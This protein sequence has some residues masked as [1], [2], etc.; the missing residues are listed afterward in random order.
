VPVSADVFG[1]VTSAGDDMGIGQRLEESAGAADYVSP[2]LYPSHYESGNLGLPDPDAAP[3]QTVYR[4]LVDARER[5]AAAGLDGAAGVRPWLQDFTWGHEYGPDE[6]RAEI[7]ATDD[8]GYTGWLLWNA[9]NVYTEAALLPEDAPA[10]APEQP[11]YLLPADEVG[12][13]VTVELDGRPLAFEDVQPFV[14]RSSGQ[15][16]IP[17]RA[18]A[19]ALGAAVEWDQFSRTAFFRREGRII[20]V[21][22][23]EAQARVN[24]SPVSLG[25]PAVLW[26]DRT[27]VPLRFLAEGFGAQVDWDGA[28][29]RV[30]IRS[31]AQP[32]D[33]R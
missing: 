29:R 15:T 27:L 6:V 33:M 12:D 14:A 31:V 28:A 11:P 19:Q 16:L 2:M 21:T 17:V 20:Q 3:Y 7:Q 5:I 18:V 13:P 26:Q 23:G 8:A 32:S 22:A 30:I 25:Q 4:S 1:L 24:G 9:A 10:P